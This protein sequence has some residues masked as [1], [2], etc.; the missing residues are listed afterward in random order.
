MSASR[1]CYTAAS[2]RITLVRPRAAAGGLV[3]TIR[4]GRFIA[5]GRVNL[6]SAEIGALP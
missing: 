6:V 2:V 1:R 5:E 3:G 4:R